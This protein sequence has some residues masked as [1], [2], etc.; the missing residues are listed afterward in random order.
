MPENN[1]TKAKTKVK[2]EPVQT[3]MD[4][5][6]YS[7]Y[8][9]GKDRFEAQKKWLTDWVNDPE[10]AKRRTFKDRNTDLL[11]ILINPTPVKSAKKRI[12]KSKIYYND[13]DKMNDVILKTLADTTGYGS[14]TNYFGR[15]YLDSSNDAIVRNT[16]KQQKEV[17]HGFSPESV[18][19]H[20]LVHLSGLD[21]QMEY[22]FPSDDNKKVRPE[23]QYVDPWYGNS[24]VNTEEKKQQ[25]P[26]EMYPAMMQFRY[27]NKIKPGQ[28]ITPNQVDSIQNSGYYNHMF[29]NFDNKTISEKL[30]TTS[31]VDKKVEQMA[32]GGKLNLKPTSAIPDNTKVKPLINPKFITNDI[33][34]QKE[35]QD[36]FDDIKSFYN[37]YL[38]SPK[39]KERLKK[40][41]Y[42]DKEIYYS[43]GKETKY[44]NN[45]D[46]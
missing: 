37:N 36:Q 4:S 14:T 10:F 29:N 23:N 46:Y 43:E 39:Y 3:P 35:D 2:K 40:S 26:S 18:A 27:D 32:K 15:S 31:S 8:N 38:D 34:N 9:Q 21:R 16:K 6:Y 11:S 25:A 13:D 5:L 20:E 17:K 7:P 30:N 24:Y 33:K 28:L 45:L 42:L 12:E 44:I 1:K 19:L 41:G 22:H